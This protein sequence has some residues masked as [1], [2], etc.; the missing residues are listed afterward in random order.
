MMEEG[1]LASDMS[2]RGRTY[3]PEKLKKVLPDTLSL[4]TRLIT[5]SAAVRD[6]TRT[7]LTYEDTL[8]LTAATR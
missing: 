8:L 3:A 1:I 2:G 4:K 6:H 7:Y 5:H